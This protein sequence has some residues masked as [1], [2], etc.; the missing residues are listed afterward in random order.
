MQETT[1][2]YRGYT[3]LFFLIVAGF[4][5][6]QDNISPPDS[7]RGLSFLPDV[8]VVGKAVKTDIA[9]LPEIVGTSIFAGKKNSLVVLKNMNAVVV[10]NNMRQVLAKVPGIH[11]WESDGSGIQIGIAARGLSPNRS[12]E[13]NIRQNGYDIASDPYGY[14]EAYYNPNMQAVQGIQIVRGAG[15]L[16]YGPQFGGMVNYILKDGSDFKKPIQFETGQTAG[17]FGL[18]NSYNGI[19]GNKG[20]IKYYAFHDYRQGNGWR[21]NSRYRTQTAFGTITWQARQNLSLTFESMA[22]N[23]SSQQAGGLTDGQFHENSRQ[24]NRSRNWF[25]T[26]WL[27][28]ALKATWEIS[29]TARL[30]AKIFYVSGDRKSVGFMSGANIRDTVN[31]TTLNFNHRDVAI[32]EY[33]NA[34]SEIGFL[35]AYK[36]LGITQHFSAGVRIFT[37]QTRR[38]QKGK[39]STSASPDYHPSGSFPVALTFD[40]MNLAFYAENMVRITQKLLLIPG[41][42]IE[43]I[44]SS[45]SGRIG[46]KSNGE[47]LLLGDQNRVRNFT[48]LGVGAEYHVGKKSEIYMNYAQAYRPI[49][50]SDLT[51]NNTTDVIDPKLSDSRGYNADFGFRGNLGKFIKTDVSFFFLSY[52]NRIGNLTQ[53]D[54]SGSIYNFRT[55][56]GNSISSGIEFYAEMDVLNFTGSRKWGL[57]VFISYNHT[58]AYYRNF[59]ITEVRNGAP[60]KLIL[61][62]KR[63]ENAPVDILRCGLS[64]RYKTLVIGGQF[65]YTGASFSDAQNTAIPSVNGNTGQIPAYRILDIN[66]IWNATENYTIRLTINNAENTRYFT[67]RSGGY[68]GPG[69]LPSDARSI[70]FSFSARF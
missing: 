13:F 3:L 58:N 60:E 33:R 37:G 11:I 25:S 63:V 54:T 5:K 64:V 12:W 8:N 68:P 28:S 26:P 27:T 7:I 43:N 18:V 66:L 10:T 51:Q 30:Q 22:Y 53:K 21:D 40:N 65:N 55:N 49:L 23:M 45:A 42:R 48:L 1:I 14:P 32:D 6:A 56:V 31:H 50:F 39:G 29:S 59:T 16:Q 67:R 62:N 24:S 4:I 9:N 35:K 36:L 38:F 2:N 41:I 46:K 20:K 17:S 19:G 15:S 52:N 69:I 34:G 57:P 61:S 70:L 44:Q 47:D